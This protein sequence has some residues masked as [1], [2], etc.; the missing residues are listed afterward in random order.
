MYTFFNA[1]LNFKEGYAPTLK[2]LGAA[3]RPNLK[4]QPPAPQN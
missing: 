3:E 2:P 4:Q 1:K